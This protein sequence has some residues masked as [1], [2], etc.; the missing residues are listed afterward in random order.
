MSNSQKKKVLVTHVYSPENKGDAALL[1]VLLKDISTVFRAADVLIAITFEIKKNDKFEGYPLYESFM[2]LAMSRFHSKPLILLYSF[3]VMFTTTL[4]AVIYKYTGFAF[5]LPEKQQT[6]MQK[7]VT[8]DVVIG[9]GGGY[10]RGQNKGIGSLLYVS[11]V[12]HPL[13]ISRI[14]RKPFIAYSQSIGPFS[15]KLEESLIAW[16]LN[17]CATTVMAR[18]DISTQLLE[19]IGVKVKTV[20]SI[21]SGFGFESQVAPIDLRKQLSIPDKLL[22]V[23][24]TAKRYAKAREQERYER[25]LAASLDKIQSKHPVYIIFIPQV[26]AAFNNDDDRLVHTRIHSYMNSDSNIHLVD[27]DLTHHEI[28]RY[29]ENLDFLIGTRFHSVIFA[30]TSRVPSIAIEYEHKTSGIMKDLNLEQW[31]VPFKDVNSKD[32]PELFSKLSRQKD[33]YREYLKKQMPVYIAKEARNKEVLSM[34]A[35]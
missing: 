1:S 18:E 21:D 15:N 9:V 7:F 34:I 35:S 5:P 32:M 17:T 26:T 3:F 23:G 16:S 20:R 19:R 27:A 2:H 14:L 10:L 4:W 25:E 28:K 6:L 29:Y 33:S 30:L 11:L 31:V 22:L 13:W 8:A 24:V 12:L